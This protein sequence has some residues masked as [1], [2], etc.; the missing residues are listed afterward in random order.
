MATTQKNSSGKS[1]HTLRKS[2]T[3]KHIKTTT[4][5]DGNIDVSFVNTTAIYA[6]FALIFFTYLPKSQIWKKIIFI[7]THS[8][9]ILTRPNPVLLVT[10]QFNLSQSSFTCPNPV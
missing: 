9:I 4:K 3:Q 7:Q 6:V 2:Q 10:I 8:F 1:T 5:G